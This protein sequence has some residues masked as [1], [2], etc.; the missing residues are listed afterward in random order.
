[1]SAFAGAVGRFTGCDWWFASAHP[2]T[3]LLLLPVNV[4]V[5]VHV[6]DSE[7]VDVDL[8]VR[9]GFPGGPHLLCWWL[10]GRREKGRRE[11]GRSGRRIR[12]QHA[13]NPLSPPPPPFSLPP[14]PSPLPTPR[15]LTPHVSNILSCIIFSSCRRS[16]ASL[17]CGCFH[18]CFL[19]L[20]SPPLFASLFADVA[21][22]GEEHKRAS[23]SHLGWTG[24][25]AFWH[26]SLNR[27]L[28][29]GNRGAGGKEI[30]REKGK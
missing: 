8:Y 16:S 13:T 19:S 22:D 1:M 9:A 14:P 17:E 2:E 7:D 29:G 20:A 21:W 12:A 4:D 6:H 10:G 23:R 30:R 26:P 24:T 11:G 15:P 28:G 3:L 27:Y 25:H 18:I 5:N